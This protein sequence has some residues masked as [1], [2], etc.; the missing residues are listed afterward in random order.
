MKSQDLG[1]MLKLICMQ[2][3]EQESKA[4]RKAWPH[5]WQDWDGGLA[6][7]QQELWEWHNPYSTTARAA[8][9]SARSL[10]HETGISKS[11]ISLSL[12]RCTET[13]LIRIDRNLGIPRVNARNLYH[14]VVHGLRYVF[15]ARAGSLT[16]G[17]A[18]SFGAPVLQGKLHS[19]G[20]FQLVWPDAAGK[21]MGLAVEPLFRS[22]TYAV[23]RDPQLYAF[24]ALLDA[25]RLGQPRESKLAAD[26]LKEQM[27]SEQ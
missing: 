3:Q 19:A 4:F 7:N 1:L 15:P 25:I 10:E 20:E 23:R 17:I 14:F 27:E 6:A 16:R 12:N 2:M 9:Y 11:Q 26:L 24:L 18:T 8:Q 5:D 22:T 21:T 13:G